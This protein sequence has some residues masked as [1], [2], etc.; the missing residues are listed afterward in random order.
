MIKIDSQPGESGEMVGEKMEEVNFHKLELSDAKWM[1][2]KH[3]EEY[4]GASDYAFANN[5]IWKDIYNCYVAEIFGCAVVRYEVEGATYYSFPYGRGDLK[6]AVATLMSISRTRNE[7]LNLEPLTSKQRDFLQ[8]HFYGKFEIH[9]QR[10]RFDYVY[11]VQDLVSLKGKKFQQKRNHINRFKDNPDWTYEKIA[12]NNIAECLEM[13][14]EW[15]QLDVNKDNPSIQAEY[16]AVKSALE[17]FDELGLIGGLLRIQGKVVAFTI[18]E[19]LNQDT[20]VVHIEKAYPDIQ[21]AYPMINQQFLIHE[22]A[23]YKYVNREED[24]GSPGLRKAKMSYRPATMI[25]KFEAV[26]SE[27]TLATPRD[28]PEIT[29]LWHKAFGDSED[30]IRF[31]LEHRFTDE[32]LYCI[33]KEGK[34]VAMT[35]AMPAT[36]KGEKEEIPVLYL[37]A[38]ATDP[39]YRKQG[40]AT[41][42]IK[43]IMDR[44]EMPLVLQPED[45]KLEKFYQSM[46]FESYFQKEKWIQSREE[47]AGEALGAM[48][49]AQ[50]FLPVDYRLKRN[51]T[52]NHQVF[53]DW[54]D[55]AIAYVLVENKY[56]GGSAM[57]LEDGVFLYRKYEGVLRV[58]ESTLPVAT[59]TALVSELLQRDPTVKTAIYENNG[60]MIWSPDKYQKIIATS[61]QG[62]LNLTLA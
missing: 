7:C 62:Y 19:Q 31:Y 4:L 34:I 47:F 39:E 17:N 43:H 38:V 1:R 22:G 15:I 10:D 37:Y 45:E 28:F 46:G 54:D 59:R 57:V 14:K 26:E 24:T 21:G 23:G 13:E 35:T 32:N 52:I 55:Y 44:H 27:I 11:E 60:G 29:D 20:L 6:K 51:A 18:G 40:L 25:H 8:E 2:E 41:K 58:I 56:L 36:L 12:G 3:R 61:K 42:I 49:F 50:D 16:K 5:Y 48:D 30:Y 9:S 33:R 53:L